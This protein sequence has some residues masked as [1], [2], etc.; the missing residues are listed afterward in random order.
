[1]KIKNTVLSFLLLTTIA[2]KAQILYSER[3]NTLTLNTGTNVNTGANYGY[4]DLPTGMTSFNNGN[5]KADTLSANYPFKAALQSTKGWLAYKPTA[6]VNVND[7]FAIS[8]SW[9]LPVG[10]ANAWMITPLINNIA[11][12]T[13]LTWDAMAPDASNA[14]GYEVYVSTSTNSIV[15]VSDF[16]IKLLTITA[17]NSMWTSRGLSLAAYAGQNIRIAFKNNSTD[18]YQLWIDDIVIENI[19]N[20]YDVAAISNETYKYALTNTTHSIAATFKNNGYQAINNLTLNYK[21]GNNS[22]VSETKSFTSPINHLETKQ[23]V[24]STSFISSLVAYNDLKIWVSNINGQNDNDATNDTITSFITTQNSAPIKKVLIEVVTQTQ[25]GWAPDGQEKLKALSTNSNVV[26][27]SVHF[28]DNYDSFSN[29]G[30]SSYIGNVTTQ[31]YPLALIDRYGFTKSPDLSVD[32]LNW[33][34]FVTKRQN[35][36]APATVSI[37]T[38]NYNPTTREITAIVSASFVGNVKGDYRLNLYVKENNVYGPAANSSWYQQSYLYNVPNSAYYQVGTASTATTNPMSYVLNE[39]EYKQQYVINDM[40]GTVDGVSG[41]IPSNGTTAG[42]TYTTSFTYTLPIA[43]N[44]E[45]RY[46]DF[47]TYL[48]ATVSEY[49]TD[50]AQ[51]NIL[52]VTETKLTTSPE[53]PVGISEQ[54]KSNVKVNLYP[55]PASNVAMLSYQIKEEQAVTIS[56][57]NTLGE[58]VLLEQTNAHVGETN[59]VIN[60]SSLLS[61][62]YSVV[63]RF[64]N[65]IATQKLTVIK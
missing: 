32:R 58:L 6:D 13:V 49:N 55:N 4:N 48:V 65:E 9:L 28:L 44:G 39:N 23:L 50:I 37:T 18:K 29:T 47:N 60:I 24:A 17:E 8:T 53:S 36:V 1:M 63:V 16:P 26:V 15:S 25:S 31:D 14:D 2:Y 38:L 56:V 62:N 43:S 64:K 12:N 19:T 34:S 22:T 10:A 57:Y 45:F 40:L 52:N 27:A 59:Q 20:Q 46:N 41:I 35:A 5:L 11:A 42:Q 21:V 30:L 3:F 61:G 51:R 7:T 33:S 54:A